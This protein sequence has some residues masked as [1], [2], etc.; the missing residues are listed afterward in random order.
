MKLESVPGDHLG[1]RAVHVGQYNQHAAAKRAGF[2][3]GDI[4][5]EV[6]GIKENLTESELMG[7]LLQR[8]SKPTKLKAIVLRNEKRLT[9]DF[10]IQ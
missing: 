7:R 3:K 9:L 2:K 6:D 5:V 8:Y 4:L 10:P 1:L